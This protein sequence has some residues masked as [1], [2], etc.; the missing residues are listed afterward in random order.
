[1]DAQDMLSSL[2]TQVRAR[3]R[4]LGMTLVELS[5]S[6]GLSVRFLGDLERGRA[7]ISVAALLRVA[8][9]LHL[10][11]ADLLQSP[12]ASGVR[13]Q[14]LE[15]LRR[16]DE[17]EVAAALAFLSRGAQ[18]VAPGT[19]VALVGLRGAGKT[20]LGKL[21]AERV[22]ARFVELDQALEERAGISLTDIFGVHGESYYRQLELEV[23]AEL[24]RDPGPLLLATGGSLVTSPDAFALLHR[25]FRTCW[26]KATPED[27]WN[28]VWEQGDHRP[29]QSHPAAM[30]RLRELLEERSPLYALAHHVVDTSALGLADSVASL[31]KLLRA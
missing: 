2:G 16:L 12:L 21:V 7:N 31:E 24:C 17:E 15:L 30:Q 22:E 1:M 8:Q 28:R 9:A 6:A 10:E 19:R 26:L 18:P 20:T 3:R 14:A 23:L 29:M 27:H 11:V 5:R 25:H 4:G 13:R